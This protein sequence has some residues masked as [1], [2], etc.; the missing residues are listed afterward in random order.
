MAPF[1]QDF[2]DFM[3]EHKAISRE[4][5]EHHFSAQTI[6]HHLNAGY[7]KERGDLI[8]YVGDSYSLG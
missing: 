8:C 7:V 4:E 1:V 5:L 2:I 3:Q 6:Q